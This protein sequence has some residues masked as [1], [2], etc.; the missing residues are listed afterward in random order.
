MAR[1]ALD[2]AAAVATAGFSLEGW[3]AYERNRL[4]TMAHQLA[5]VG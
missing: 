1:R 5:T 2:I 3:R 4:R